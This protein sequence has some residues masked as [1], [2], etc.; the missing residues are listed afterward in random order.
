MFKNREIRVS[1]AKKNNDEAPATVALPM[2]DP[3]VMKNIMKEYVVKTAIVIGAV[4]A[5]NLVVSAACQI[6]VSAMQANSK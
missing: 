3:E 2:D 1:L 5:V 6:A 4:V